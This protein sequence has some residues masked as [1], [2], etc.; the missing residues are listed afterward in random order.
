MTLT[1]EQVKRARAAAIA[2]G[3]P[4][5]HEIIHEV[6]DVMG[7][8]VAHVKGTGLASGLKAARVQ[9]YLCADEAGFSPR[10]IAD[11]MKRDRSTVAQVIKNHKA[12]ESA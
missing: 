8:K 4:R 10:Q 9:I 5:L 3:L 6:C 11:V 2:D 1:A 12:G 7:V